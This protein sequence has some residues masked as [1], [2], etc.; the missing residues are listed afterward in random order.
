MEGTD[1]LY[2]CTVGTCVFRESNL[3]CI[4]CDVKKN[5]KDICAS[6]VENKECHFA[7]LC[8]LEKIIEEL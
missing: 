4:A 7:I 1:G 6:E 2:L 5:C 3:C 8:T